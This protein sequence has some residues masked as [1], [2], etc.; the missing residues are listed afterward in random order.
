MKN[1]HCHLPIVPANNRLCWGLK[2][3]KYK[4]KYINLKGGRLIDI[5]NNPENTVIKTKCDTIDHIT[6]NF[7]LCNKFNE[8][9]V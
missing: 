9:S 2:Y 7:N 5:L 8:I 3:L 1:Y 4:Q 6:T